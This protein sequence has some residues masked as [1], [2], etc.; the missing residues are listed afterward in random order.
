MIRV[1]RQPPSSQTYPGRPVLPMLAMGLIAIV[2]F[3]PR[4]ASATSI[5]PMLFEEL[6]LTTD[7]VGIVECEQ[8]GGIVAKYRIVESWKGPLAGSS[9]SI[10]Q[11]PNPSFYC[12]PIITRGTRLFVTAYKASAPHFLSLSGGRGYPLLWRDIPADYELPLLQGS[13]FL[14][15]PETKEFKKIRHAARILLDLPP[16]QQEAALLKAAMKKYLFNNEWNF[17]PGGERDK[18]RHAAA[19]RQLDNITTTD[20]LVT[21]IIRLPLLDREKWACRTRIVLEK[22]G[23]NVALKHMEKLPA[24]RSPWSKEDF[25]SLMAIIRYRCGPEDQEQPI[26][27]PAP[28][29]KPPTANELAAARRTLTTGERTDG[30]DQAQKILTLHDPAPVVI[31][32]NNWTLEQK[33]WYDLDRGYILGSY[34]A[35]RCGKDRKKHLTALLD[36]KDPYIRVAGAIYLCYEDL[37]AGQAALKKLTELKGA[38]GAWAA[39]T[40]ARRGVKD[41][42]SRA[43]KLFIT[44]DEYK[45]EFWEATTYHLQCRMLILLSNSA[46]TAWINL[47]DFPEDRKKHH[48]CIANWWKQNGDKL[49]LG[50]PWLKILEKQKVD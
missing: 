12:S 21:E 14:T 48:Q 27:T 20:A 6:I 11:T 29:K 37:D 43:L 19:K 46:R 5:D 32:L 40:L 17:C 22:G 39:L 2:L 23:C 1:H 7:F 26:A 33:L 50:D 15:Q 3:H 45:K 18:T 4:I 47:P 34:F 13:E 28:K 30:F 16:E 25:R 9:I 36:A 38:P 41:A 44:R 24:N 49:V 35:F 42:V 31:Y 10:R 8:A